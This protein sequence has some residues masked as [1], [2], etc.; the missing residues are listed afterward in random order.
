MTGHAHNTKLYGSRVESF[1]VVLDRFP[2]Y[3]D[4]KSIGAFSGG[5]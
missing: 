3:S 2:L 4:L 5:G 1:K